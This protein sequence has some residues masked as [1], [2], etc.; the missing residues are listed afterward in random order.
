MN[1]QTMKNLKN[2]RAA[3]EENNSEDAK[4]F[5]DMV[6]IDEPENGEAKFFYQYYSLY[7]GK[8]GEIP[9]RFK[10]LTTTLKSSV[11]C[12]AESNESDEEKMSVLSAIVSSFVPMTWS[13]N[14][15]MNT[16]FVG[17]GENRQRVIPS[18]EISQ[19]C[20]VGV[21]ALYDLGDSI[22]KL[23]SGDEAMK[24]AA[25]AWKEGVSLQQKWYA[26]KYNGKTPEEYTAKIQKVEPEYEMPKKAGCISFANKR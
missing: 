24:L 9:S 13:L 15:Y 21:V 22:E 3:R 26:Y 16:L 6:R 10:T 17:S 18:S 25:N 11:R 7:E 1:E 5:Y 12:I 19:S 2:A 8:N 23:F 4:K 20:I 14:R